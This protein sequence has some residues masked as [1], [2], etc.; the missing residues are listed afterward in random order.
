MG[1]HTVQQVKRISPNPWVVSAPQAADHGFEPTHLVQQ[2]LVLAPDHV[3]GAGEPRLGLD[4][5]R[6][7]TLRPFALFDVEPECLDQRT[8]V[9]GH[10][11]RPV[12]G[13]PSDR[14]GQDFLEID[15]RSAH[16]P[17]VLARPLE[18]SVVGWLGHRRHLLR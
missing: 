6:Q 8:D 4:Y 18:S 17:A 11:L 15:G 9:N 12:P 13:I 3:D 10:V 7:Q 16:T 14:P 5:L 2:G 1:G